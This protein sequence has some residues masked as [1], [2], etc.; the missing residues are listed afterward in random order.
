MA[1]NTHPTDDGLQDLAIARRAMIRLF[2]ADGVISPEER[3]VVRLFDGGTEEI[4]QGRRLERAMDFVIRA[5]GVMSRYGQQLANEAGLSIVP[6][7]P[8]KSNVV[9][10]FE[11]Q[12]A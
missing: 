2:A 7:E 6:F 12:Q 11:D 4:A 1:N 9:T 3:N 10:L 5:R 8:P